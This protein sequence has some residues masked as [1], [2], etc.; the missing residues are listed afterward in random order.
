M[1]RVEISK[2]VLEMFEMDRVVVISVE[3]WD[4]PGN[5]VPPAKKTLKERLCL[6]V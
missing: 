4:F 3:K 1:K 5:V 2:K 6:S